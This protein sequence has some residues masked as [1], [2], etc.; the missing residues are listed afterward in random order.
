M[1]GQNHGPRQEASRPFLLLCSRSCYSLHWTLAVPDL[2]LPW[3]RPGPH[4]LSVPPGEARAPK[5]HTTQAWAVSA[6]LAGLWP[7]GAAWWL[8][9]ELVPWLCPCS[10]ESQGHVVGAAAQGTGLSAGLGR[11]GALVCFLLEN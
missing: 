11:K 4:T 9:A 7:Q 3:A 8:R 6:L 2:A 5:P 1:L 10:V